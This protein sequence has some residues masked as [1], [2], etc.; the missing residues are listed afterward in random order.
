M[1]FIESGKAEGAIAENI[2]TATVL[3]YLNIAAE[4]QSTW[5]TQKEYQ[6]KAAGLYQLI[7]YGLIGS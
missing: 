4:V 2:A 1:Q 7:L 6:E 3:Q 5:E